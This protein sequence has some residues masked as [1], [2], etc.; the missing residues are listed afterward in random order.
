MN[1]G[2]SEPAAHQTE[3]DRQDARPVLDHLVGNG[4]ET[5]FRN[6]KAHAF[7]RDRSS[8]DF[9]MARRIMSGS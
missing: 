3:A 1:A 2:G 9:R 7:A 8:A 5:R 4:A 6:A